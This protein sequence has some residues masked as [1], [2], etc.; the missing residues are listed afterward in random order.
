MASF[1]ADSPGRS[2]VVRG[3]GPGGAYLVTTIASWDSM[4]PNEVELDGAAATTVVA[5]TQG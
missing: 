2:V 1:D 4:N 3:A 5:A